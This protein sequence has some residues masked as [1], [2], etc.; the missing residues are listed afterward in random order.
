MGISVA[1]QAK[2]YP[3]VQWAFQY[4]ERNAFVSF[5]PLATRARPNKLIHLKS[6]HFYG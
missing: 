1:V 6:P 5:L 2:V 3:F 4:S